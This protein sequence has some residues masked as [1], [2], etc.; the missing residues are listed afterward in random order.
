MKNT[1]EGV[2]LHPVFSK[3]LKNSGLTGATITKAGLHIMSRTE[4]INC[5]GYDP[6]AE[7]LSFPYPGTNGYKRLKPATPLIIEDKPRKYLAPKNGGNHLYILPQSLMPDEFLRDPSKPLIITEGEKKTL[8]G[9]QEGFMVIGIPGV[10]CWKQK[11]NGR[12]KPVDEFKLI[13]WRNRLVY[14]I[15]DSDAVDNSQIQK[16]EAQLFAEILKRGGNPVIGRIPKPNGDDSDRFKGKFG[17][18]DFLVARGPEAL[19]EV[20]GKAK[21]HPQ[22]YFYGKSFKPPLLSEELQQR[23]I[24]KR[25]VD[26]NVGEG[27]LYIFENG[28]YRKAENVE[29]EAQDLLG[30]LSTKNRVK[31]AVYHLKNEVSEFNVLMNPQQAVI[32]CKNGILD[33]ISGTLKPHDSDYLSS[34]QLPI[35]WNPDAKCERLDQ[36]LHEVFP[37]D[38]LELADEIIGYLMI[39]DIRFKKFF[40][41][42]GPGNNGKSVFLALVKELL[43]IWNCSE[44]ALQDFSDNRF[45]AEGLEDKLINVFDDLSAEALK[46]TG[47]IKMVTGSQDGTIVIEKKHRSRYRVRLSARMIFS[48]NEMPRALDHSPAWYERLIIIPFRNTFSLKKN[49]LDREVLSKITTPP[50]LQRLFSRG[51]RGAQR[52][53]QR[54]GFAVPDSVDEQLRTYKMKNDNVMAFV[55]ECCTLSPEEQIKRTDLYQSYEDYCEEAGVRP[56]SRRNFYERLKLSL[57]GITEKKIHGYDFFSGIGCEVSKIRLIFG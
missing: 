36:F 56:V 3:D 43:G 34:I 39:P 30:M 42:L 32:N 4:S 38:C 9:V 23:N 28:V 10:F 25:C 13:K 21:P 46:K 20:L 35:T 31:E 40:I 37:P 47:L 7:C 54:G 44:I 16:A 2:L 14:I 33:V 11:G 6:K 1:S 55:D 26:R 50:A 48:A 51:V 15:F 27:Q 5:L 57:E 17:L 52:L 22:K 24:Y 8:K 19:K 12:S 49:N 41:L 53:Y 29:K 18:D 45:A